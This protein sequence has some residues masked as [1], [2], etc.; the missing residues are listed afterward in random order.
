MLALPRAPSPPL[1]K[2][3][4]RTELIYS[5]AEDQ[6]YDLDDRDKETHTGVCR[7]ATPTPLA[8]DTTLE[9][10]RAAKAHTRVAETEVD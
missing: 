1:F 9:R 2:H 5:F 8:R 7:A 10:P 4:E 6:N 3:V